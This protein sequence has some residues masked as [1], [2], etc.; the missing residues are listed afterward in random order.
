MDQENGSLESKCDQCG[1]DQIDVERANLTAS[2]TIDFSGKENELFIK[3]VKKEGSVAVAK[4][5]SKLVKNR[6]PKDMNKM[7]LG[8]YTCPRLRGSQRKILGKLKVSRCLKV[9]NVRGFIAV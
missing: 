3:G 6:V 2:D 1:L 4:Y 7:C 8:P 9:E 5:R